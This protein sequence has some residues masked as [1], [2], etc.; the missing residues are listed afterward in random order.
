MYT[1]MYNQTM[2]KVLPVSQV[3]AQLPKLVDE[4]D[5]QETYITVKGKLKAALVNASDF[6]AMKETLEVLNDEELM[7]QIK[8]GEADIAAG[9]TV[10]WEDVKKELGIEG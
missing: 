10:S 5:V 2:T 7:M 4:T 9:R 3:R 6:L 8:E 1:F